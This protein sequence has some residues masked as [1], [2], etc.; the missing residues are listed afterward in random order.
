MEALAVSSAR[1]ELA[2]V[3]DCFGSQQ[4]ASDVTGVV[5]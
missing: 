2:K 3:E 1:R 5:G 4:H